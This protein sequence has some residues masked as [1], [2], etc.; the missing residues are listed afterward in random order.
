MALGYKNSYN[1][2]SRRFNIP[3]STAVRW[4]KQGAPMD[5][6]KKLELWVMA[7]RSRPK[8]F[9]IPR[10]P[11]EETPA[12]SAGKEPASPSVRV[13]QPLLDLPVPPS[14]L[15]RGLRGEIER[16]EEEC[17]TNYELYQAATRSD[18]PQPV[19]LQTYHKLWMDS[20]DALRKMRKDTP[21]SEQDDKRALD[22]EDV[23]GAQTR[24]LKEFKTRLEM[25][26]RRMVLVSKGLTPGALEKRWSDEIALV[27]GDLRVAFARAVGVEVGKGEQDGHEG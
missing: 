1:Y 3:V 22:R 12:G 19:L 15:V 23:V 10:A 24:A 25:L 4:C 14:A 11:Q 9:R 18:P 6:D 16:L 26:P 5:N 7:K 2:Y 8:G 20:Q 13:P 21:K 17:I 27:V